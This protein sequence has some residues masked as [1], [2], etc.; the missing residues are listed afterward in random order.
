EGEVVDEWRN[1]HFFY[2]ASIFGPHLDR[3]V[4]GDHILAAV[5]GDVIINTPL[6]GVQQGTLSVVTTTDD[7][8]DTILDSHTPDRISM[9]DVHRH[10]HRFWSLKLDHV[11]PP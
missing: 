4:N 8:G 2:S 6:Q 5:T 11:F 7:Q 3:I 10:F 9:G 1:V